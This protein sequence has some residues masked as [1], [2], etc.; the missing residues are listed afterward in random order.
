MNKRIKAL[1]QNIEL[2]QIALRE[3]QEVKRDADE[4]VREAGLALSAARAR[5]VKAKE[6]IDRKLPQCKMVQVQSWRPDRMV[7]ACIVGVTKGGKLR[8]R[9]ILG[10][11]VALFSWR[12]TAGRYEASSRD[13]RG[14]LI[15][16]PAESAR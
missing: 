5:L 12:V 1:K 7:E 16:V 15:D 13:F 8:V 9:P 4:K 10:D 14:Y 2:L 3:A 11:H 6:A